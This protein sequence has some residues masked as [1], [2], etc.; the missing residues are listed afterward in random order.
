MITDVLLHDDGDAYHLHSWTVMPN[1]VHTLVT[2]IDDDSLPKVVKGWKSISARR[3]NRIAN[4]T[5]SVWQRGYFDRFMRDVDQF[6]RTVRYIEYNPVK[7]NLCEAPS[8]WEWGSAHFRVEK[9]L[10]VMDYD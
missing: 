3:I 2:V 7:A 6:W 10:K 8:D 1:H 4:R 5:G 9:G